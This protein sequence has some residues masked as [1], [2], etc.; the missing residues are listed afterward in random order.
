LVA[1]EVRVLAAV[2]YAFL[3]ITSIFVLIALSAFFGARKGGDC[4]SSRDDGRRLLAG[5]PCWCCWSAAWRYRS[6]ST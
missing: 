6:Q 3:G 4:S 2:L 1:A 5:R